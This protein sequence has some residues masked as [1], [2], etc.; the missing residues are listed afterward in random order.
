MEGCW[1]QWREVKVQKEEMRRTAEEVGERWRASRA[2]KVWR[3]ALRRKEVQERKADVAREFFLQRAAWHQ[4]LEKVAERRRARWVEEK[5]R[6]RK[7]EMLLCE[8]VKG[9]SL[10]HAPML[11]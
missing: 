1:D 7:R 4:L 8:S 6:K 9:S 3:E 11:T 10:R 5:V 2:M